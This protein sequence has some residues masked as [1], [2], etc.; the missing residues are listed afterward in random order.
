MIKQGSRMK[1]FSL[2]CMLAMVIACPWTALAQFSQGQGRNPGH[3]G[4]PGHAGSP[5][6]PGGGHATHGG[7][8]HPPQPNPIHHYGGS[9]YRPSTGISFSF[10]TGNAGIS[11]R[12]GYPASNFGYGANYGYGYP[13]SYYG[14]AP[15]YSSYRMVV[16]TTTLSQTYLYSNSYLGYGVNGYSNYGNNLYNNSNYGYN[17][18][19]Y[20]S[21]RYGNTNG[22]RG[23]GDEASGVGPGAASAYAAGI[24][25]LG[26]YSGNDGNVGTVRGGANPYSNSSG[27]LRPGMILPDGAQVLSVG[28]TAPA[29]TQSIPVTPGNQ[30]V[31]KL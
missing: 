19:G 13:S 18:Y 1:W 6:H 31:I 7:W 5:G 23:Y 27:D 22:N 11:Y 25:P 12:S 4:G 28:P 14:Y 26:P 3:A 2:A 10:S 24:T 16:P 21:S 15:G 30:G 9:A 8:S 17:S 20:G 29:T